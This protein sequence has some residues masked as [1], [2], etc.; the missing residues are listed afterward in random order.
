I[1]YNGAYL[2][3]N[4]TPKSVIEY[5]M[6]PNY[7][8]I[9]HVYIPNVRLLYFGESDPTS[10]FT[11]F[12]RGELK[13]APVYA[14]NPGMYKIAKKKYS[15]SIFITDSGSASFFGGFVFDRNSYASPI[16]KTQDVSVKTE[17]QR[18][19]TKKAILN[20]QFR[21]S[22]VFALNTSM[23]NA[24]EVGEDLK[25]TSLRN[26][27]SKPDF[28]YSSSGKTFGEMVSEQLT[29]LNDKLYPEG[30]DLN[31]GQMAYY[32]VEVARLLMSDAKR[33]LQK[34]GVSFPVYLDLQVNGD[35]DMSFRSAQALKATLEKNLNQDII[36]NLII[37]N[38]ESLVAVKRAEQVN[39]DLVFATAWSPDYGDPKTY[40]DILDPDS[41]DMLK[42]F[43]LNF[44]GREVGDDAKIKEEIGLYQFKSL[45]DMAN[46][47]VGNLDIRYELYAKAEAYIL[48]QA[49]IIPYGV[50]GG[51]YAVTR[52]VPYTKI[53]A[54]Y[55]LS[56]AKF[57]RMQISDE[58][59]TVSERETLRV[60]WENQIRL[61]NG[62]GTV[63]E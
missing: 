54:P 48:D 47:E 44:S 2:L 19:D 41:G 11:M 52:A 40:L 55:G 8:D 57:K 37:S 43:G 20:Q 12:D 13:S 18:A 6:N 27:L 14:N 60:E 29:K 3:K 45:K 49:Y 26:T 34:E 51:S 25:Y 24:Q 5:E 53:Y 10:I 50:S 42:V 16:D 23:V 35:N 9:E 31:D 4:F 63:S 17:K 30:L 28:V 58:V 36:I 46:D 7:W 61:L 62:Q 59:I 38:T 1:L 56:G 21:Q 32:N 33:A 39:A 15:D 22:I